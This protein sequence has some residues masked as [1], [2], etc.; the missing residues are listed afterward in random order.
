MTKGS[1]IILLRACV[2]SMLS[3]VLI[4]SLSVG[5]ST[6]PDADRP[7][8]FPALPSW[9]ESG[10]TTTPRKL[11]SANEPLSGFLPKEVEEVVDVADSKYFRTFL[12]IFSVLA[13]VSCC[14]VYTWCG[15]LLGWKWIR[16]HEWQKYRCAPG[17]RMN[18]FRLYQGVLHTYQ[19]TLYRAGRNMQ[20]PFRLFS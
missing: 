5:C 1:Q 8:I 10:T 17:G 7:D 9:A 13:T 14:S 16:V 20:N 2:M 19:M 18:D 12:Q 15:S 3:L 6:L 4:S 11:P